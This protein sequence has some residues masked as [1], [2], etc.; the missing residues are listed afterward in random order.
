MN[1]PYKNLD[2]GDLGLQLVEKRHTN[3]GGKYAEYLDEIAVIA[4]PDGS[5]AFTPGAMEAL[6]H[7]VRLNC[8]KGNGGVVGFQPT[9]ELSGYK[10]GRG[11]ATNGSHHGKLS[12]MAAAYFCQKVPTLTSQNHIL[13]WR[14]V[15]LDGRMIVFTFNAP[16]AQWEHIRKPR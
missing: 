11:K 13:L 15:I 12:R 7:P 6:N 2:F 14:G 4:Y 3:D 10:L 9:T 8:L 1:K 16:I 5:L